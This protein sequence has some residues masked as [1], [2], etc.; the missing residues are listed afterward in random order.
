MAEFAHNSWEHEHTKHTPHELI[1]GFNPTASFTIP[2]DSIPATQERLQE[3]SKSRSEAQQALQKR[4]KPVLPLRSFAPEDKVWLDARNLHIRTP[5]RKLSNR[6]IGPYV[7][8]VQL[9]PVT[10]R[11]HLPESMKI[12]DVFHVDLLT[13]YHETDAYGLPPPQPPAILVDGQEE[14]KVESIIND[15]YN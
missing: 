9:S 3:L 5:S 11:L 15:R 14:Y 1:H 6:R 4:S 10:Y 2:E 8:N 7:I 13:P 12:H